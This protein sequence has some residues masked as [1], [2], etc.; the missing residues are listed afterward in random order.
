M[1]DI[2]DLVKG[3]VFMIIAWIQGCIMALIPSNLR[4]KDVS[5]DIVLITG[6]GSGIGQLVAIKFAKL[7][8]TV[9]LWDLNQA[10]M[11]KTAADIKKVGGRCHTYICDVSNRKAVY[12][13]AQR[14][15]EEVGV[16]SILMN[17]AG[18][19]NGKRLLKLEDEKIIKTFEVNTF[20]HFWT[21]KA[22]LPDMMSK[23]K[24]HII[25]VSSIAGMSGGCNISDYAASKFANIGFEESLRYELKTDGY[26][27]IV[28]TMV[29]PW[30][31][32]TGLF[33]GAKSEV[34]PFL[35]PEFVA[36]KIIEG[37]LINQEVIMIPRMLYYLYVL[38]SFLPVRAMFELCVLL[39]GHSAMD[40]FVGRNGVKTK[41]N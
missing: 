15:K 5:S 19:V 21:C 31:I 35:E 16:V 20:A 38:K 23:N 26:D 34:I 29:C 3:V 1:D 39:K 33:A 7:G 28:S 41:D 27:G 30:F 10:G 11:N 37:V 2:V 24:G 9:V 13:V 18:I 8:S 32:N 12:E 36:K 17:N 6:G 4:L 14:V 22:F 25:T 40:T